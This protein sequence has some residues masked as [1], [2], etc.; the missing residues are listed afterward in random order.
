M[1]GLILRNLAKVLAFELKSS[2]VPR[3]SKGFW[4]G[5]EDISPDDVYVVAPVKEPYPIKQGAK[6]TPLLDIIARFD[7][8]R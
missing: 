4:N 5:L 2:T 8:D 1:R 7:A 3:V 6:V